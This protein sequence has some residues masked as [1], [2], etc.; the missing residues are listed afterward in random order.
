MKKKIPGQ[1]NYTFLLLGLFAVILIIFS[2]TKFSTL[3]SMATWKSMSMQFPEYG[4]FTLGV[5]VCFITGNMDLSFVALGDF[6]SIIACQI[7][8]LATDGTV[9]ESQT[10]LMIFLGILA[11]LAIGAIGGF[12]NGNLISRLRIP[13]VLATLATQQLFR[14]ISTGI[15][16]GYAVTGIPGVFSEVGH[17]MVFGFI[18]MPLL[19]FAVIFLIIGFMVK[20]TTYGEK[21]YMIGS[22]PKAAKFSAINTTRMV[23]ATFMISGMCAAIGALLMV[24]SMNSAKADYGSSYLMRCILILVLA[25]VLPD[26]GMGKIFNVLISII[27]I[28]V[29]ATCVNMFPELN[30]YYGNLIWGTLLLVVLMATSRLL[31]ERKV[32]RTDKKPV[33]TPAA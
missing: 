7:M 11:A 6:A 17:S 22:N 19:I 27:T 21:L 5:M 2:I 4:V 18:P 15:T 14:G 9:P 32:R 10:G 20:Y 23:N 12:L 8:L 29:I 16:K 26:G 1:N 28:Q 25:G 24:S 33:P 30:S 31:G 3:W 13:P